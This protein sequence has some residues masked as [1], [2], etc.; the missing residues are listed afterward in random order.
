MISPNTPKKLLI[1]GFPSRRLLAQQVDAWSAKPNPEDVDDTVARPM[2]ADD[3]LLAADKDPRF[4]IPQRTTSQANVCNLVGKKPLD[5]KS[6]ID[7]IALCA[8]L[9]RSRALMET[10]TQAVELNCLG[11]DEEVPANTD[12]SGERLAHG[13]RQAIV[14]KQLPQGGGVQRSRL[15]LDS[16]ACGLFRRMMLFW[17]VNDM[18]L[19]ANLFTDASPVTGVEIQGMIL[20]LCMRT[21]QYAEYVLPGTC[22]P[23]GHNSAHDKAAL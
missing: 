8:K 21:G 1:E 2:L 15:R 13:H 7:G 23:Y 6:T 22:M 10:F 5:I 16:T 12:A 14:K 9:K 20:E 3:A 17:M 11:S 19:C 18:V 4:V